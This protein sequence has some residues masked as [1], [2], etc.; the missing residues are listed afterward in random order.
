MVACGSHVRYFWGGRK[1]ERP[2]TPVSHS[3]NARYIVPAQAAL[4]RLLPSSLSQHTVL[5]PQRKAA[6]ILEELEHAYAR[7]KDLW[8]TL[9]EDLD[10]CGDYLPPPR[11]SEVLTGDAILTLLKLHVRRLRSRVSQWTSSKQSHFSR[12]R[13]RLWTKTL[14]QPPIRRCFASFSESWLET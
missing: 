9:E 12:R 5:V 11:S 1:R 10:R 8:A 14:A 6:R 3:S 2:F 4:P 13:P 7:R